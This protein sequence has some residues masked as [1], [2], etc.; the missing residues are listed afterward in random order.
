MRRLFGS[1][2]RGAK[3]KCWAWPSPPADREP[4]NDDYGDYDGGGEDDNNGDGDGYD[5]NGD[6]DNGD[7]EDEDGQI[8][9]ADV[10]DEE[11]FATPYFKKIRWPP[12][13]QYW[14]QWPCS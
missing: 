4:D 2:S 10:A 5:V 6:V 8:G 13:G 7:D 11:F 12:I 9:A 14:S 1:G 3:T